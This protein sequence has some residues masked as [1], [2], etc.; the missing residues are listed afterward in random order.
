MALEPWQLVVLLCAATGTAALA[1][2]LA[3]QSWERWQMS[4][5]DRQGRLLER[6]WAVIAQLPADMLNDPLRRAIGGIMHQH[7]RR[8]QRLQPDHPYLR[9]QREH[10][11]RFMG[12]APA[13]APRPRG[14]QRVR[15]LSAVKDFEALLDGVA[16]DRLVTQH[17][18]VL[19]R[20]AAARTSTELEFLQRQQSALTPEHL[21]RVTRAIESANRL[22]GNQLPDSNSRLP[23]Q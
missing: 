16:P 4:R 15:A 12:Q 20:A 3:L 21:R 22:W 10:I 11:A 1:L 14:E 6:W 9:A 18:L 2:R 13:G 23:T 8:A 5:L 7:L 19:C 17:D